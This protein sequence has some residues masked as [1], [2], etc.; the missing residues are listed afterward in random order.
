MRV[1]ALHHHDEDSPGLIGQALESFGANVDL[2]F[3]GE[4][5]PVPS[6]EGYDL[7]MILGSKESAYDEAVREA[8]FNNELALMAEA[9]ERGLPI[10]GICFGAQALCTMAGGTVARAAEGEIGWYDVEPAV[11]DFD[12]GPWFEF[13]YDECALPETATIWARSPR[14]VQAF[15]I[16]RHVGVQFHPEIDSEQLR[17]WLESGAE[18]ARDFGRDPEALLAE[19]AALEEGARARAHRLVERVLRHNGL[20]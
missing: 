13:H 15:A 10:F 6:L 16:G 2:V 12:S 20:I 5:H 8:W 4:G 19:T 11:A 1:L 3:F 17:E 9:D 7:L 18:E 14:A